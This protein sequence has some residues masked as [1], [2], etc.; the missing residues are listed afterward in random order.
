MFGSGK[1]DIPLKAKRTVETVLVV[2]IF[3]ALA[4]LLYQNSSNHSF[5]LDSGHS[6][7]N[8]PFVTDLEFVPSYF[9]NPGTFSTLRSN[10]DYR[11]VLQTSYALNYHF[12]SYEMPGWHYTQ[13]AIHVWC[14]VWLFYFAQLVSLRSGFDQGYSRISGVLVSAIFLIHPTQSGVVNYLSARSSALTAAWLLPS[15][16]FYLKSSSLRSR[17]VS[18][19]LF[20]LAL[21]TKVEAIAGLAVYFML[22]LWNSHKDGDSV[23]ESGKAYLGRKAQLKM[24]ALFLFSALAY[25]VI[26]SKVMQG[27]PLADSALRAGMT[28]LKYLATQMTCWWFYVIKWFA[29]VDL[30]ADNMH[31]PVYELTSPTVLMAGGVWLILLGAFVSQWSQRPYLLVCLGAYISLLSPTSSIVPLSEMVNEHRPYLPMA[32]FSMAWLLPMSRLFEEKRR[33]IPLCFGL[34]AITIGLCGATVDRNR[35][36]I[37]EKSFWRDVLEKAPSARAHVNYG[38]TLMKEGNYKEASENFDQALKLAPNYY[39]AHINSAILQNRLGD[40][41]KAMRHYEAAVALDVRTGTAL[42]WR[43]RWHLE[44]RRYRLALRDLEQARVNS[45]EHYSIL[46]LEAEAHLG[47]G[48]PEKAAAATLAAAALNFEQLEKDIV[49]IS[50]PVFIA[51]HEKVGID[52]FEELNSSGWHD[53]WWVSSNLEMLKNRQNSSIR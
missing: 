42:V 24:F 46:T 49:V 28:P 44:H 23:L 32:V 1:N 6:V 13:V 45:L 53:V 9:S 27:Y 34:I 39:I 12:S 14:A 4:S 7:R 33:S 20:V 22:D 26:R 43:A 38:L 47:E 48:E 50:Q 25:L 18:L 19:L 36:F 30:V 37:T 10:V 21:F 11:P 17:L 3:S 31:Y 15:F 52:F 51:G 29:P 40:Q 41:E 35:V 8:N 16:Y 2:L 5:H